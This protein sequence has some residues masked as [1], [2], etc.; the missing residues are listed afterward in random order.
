MSTSGEPQRGI[1]LAPSPVAR[2]IAKVYEMS[3]IR[4]ITSAINISTNVLEGMYDNDQAS[5]GWVGETQARTDTNT[6]EVG[7]YRIEAHEMY[8]QP[9][10]SQTLLDD[11][12]VDVEA[13]LQNKV[14]TRFA[15]V[16]SAA[17][18]NG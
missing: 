16:E 1:T 11:A 15:R 18:I 13:W 7:K 6:P 2:M 12:A 14:S 17:F 8:A 10:A 5:Y 4:H 9:K 3:P